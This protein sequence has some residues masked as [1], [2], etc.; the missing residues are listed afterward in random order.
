MSKQ[1]VVQSNIPLISPYGKSLFPAIQ[2]R[3]LAYMAMISVLPGI[4]PDD[5]ERYCDTCHQV[6]TGKRNG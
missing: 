5:V 1:L 3:V 4:K 2:T 6:L